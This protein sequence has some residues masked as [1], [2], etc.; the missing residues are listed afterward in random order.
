MTSNGGNVESEGDTCHFAHATDQVNVTPAEL[1]LGPLADNL[2]PTDTH[3]LLPGSVAIDAAVLGDCPMVDQRGFPRPELG[4]TD[5]DSGAFERQAEAVQ[6]DINPWSKYNPIYPFSRLIISVALLGSDDF[7]VADVDVTTLA[8]GPNG[9][10]PALDLTNP[11]VFLFSHWDVNDDDKTDL[12]AHFRTEETGIALGATEA[13]LT[14]RTLDGTPFAGCDAI[15]TVL[16][17]GH[18]FE[19]ALVVPPLVWIGGRM[20]R[21]R[22]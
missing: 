7:D 15:A 18:G 2:G 17:C 1:A 6:I 9:A 3:A 16:G 21:R 5:C 4:G 12:L 19:A 14:G 10:P 22:R 8:F 11:W 13:C 20:R